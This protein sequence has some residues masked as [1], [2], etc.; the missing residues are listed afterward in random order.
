MANHHNFID[1][2]DGIILRNFPNKNMCYIV[3]QFLYLQFCYNVYI[4]EDLRGTH[5]WH[6]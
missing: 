1:I 3:I 5:S 2:R 6:G 4:H